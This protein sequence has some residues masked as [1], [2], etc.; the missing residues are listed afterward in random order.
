M[1]SPQSALEKKIESKVGEVRTEAIDISFGE[2]VNLHASKPR[3]LIIQPEYQRL[4]R[5]SHGQ[6]SRLIE[7][8]LLDL[9]IPQIFVIE[10]DDGVLELI[11]GLQRISSVLHFID[12]MLI[13]EAVRDQVAPEPLVLTGC[14]LLSDL[15]GLKFTD[16]PLKLKLNLKRSSVRMVTIK[17]TSTHLL[18]YEMF[19]RLNTGGSELSPQEIRNCTS[20]MVGPSGIKFYKFLRESANYEPFKNC[21]ASLPDPAREQKGDEELVLRF[22]T[23]KNFRDSFEGSVRDWL[24]DYM[25]NVLLEK[26]PFDY[27]VEGA[28][29]KKLFDFL[30]EKFGEAA[31]VK[32]RSGRPIGALAPA[33]FEAVAVGLIPLVDKLKN[34]PK[35]K[36]VSKLA[37]CVEAQSF[38]TNTGPGANSKQKLNERV[39]LVNSAFENVK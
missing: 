37:E 22:L 36:L 4:F 8:I 16:L 20:R 38:R 2:L 12:Y 1:P 7:S 14:D 13:D 3:E 6:R 27:D 21:I 33:Y 9:P 39:S 32:Y 15:N 26:I 34:V 28:A 31:F 19:K 18:R 25:D 30:G 5:W 23:T 10:N 35:E 24:D 29:F 17:K 11:D